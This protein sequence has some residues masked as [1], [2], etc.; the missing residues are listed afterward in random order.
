MGLR[1]H[2][3]GLQPLGQV[4]SQH[5]QRPRGS[6]Q[7]QL[8]EAMTVEDVLETFR[9]DGQ[10][11]GFGLLASTDVRRGGGG[12]ACSV[13]DASTGAGGHPLRRCQ[14]GDPIGVLGQRSA[15]AGFLEQAGLATI[16][17]KDE[18]SAIEDH[19][20]RSLAP[21]MPKAASAIVIE[22]KLSICGPS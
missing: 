8:V 13:T 7:D 11:V 16:G 17:D 21:I 12:V 19:R 6:D 9:E 10:E 18:R 20:F 14:A 22:I 15:A 4:T 5:A 1:Q 2:Q 3:A